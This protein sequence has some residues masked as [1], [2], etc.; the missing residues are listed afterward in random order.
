MKDFML[1]CSMVVVYPE[2]AFTFHRKAHLSVLC[3]RVIHLFFVPAQLS[4]NRE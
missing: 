3:E 4:M 2:V 1:I